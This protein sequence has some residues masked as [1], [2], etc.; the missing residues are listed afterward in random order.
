MKITAVDTTLMRIPLKQRAI[1]DS[2]SIVHDVEFMQVKIETD[3]GVTGWGMNWSYTP[4]LRAA[5][6][7]VTDNYIPLLVGQDPSMRKELTRRCYYSNHFV[8]R[9]GAAQVGLCAVE[10]ALWDIACKTANLPLWRFLGPCRDKVKAYSTDGGWLSAT[11]DELVRDAT[12]LVERGFDAV[13]IKLGRSDPHED[14]QRVGAVRKAIGPRVK[15]MTD[16]KRSAP[17]ATGAA[18]SPSM[19]CSGSKSPCTR[20]TRR[21]MLSLRAAFRSRS[22][23]VKPSTPSGIFATSSSKAE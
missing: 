1:T 12:A 17:L 7:C 20:S 19:T 21:R 9:V 16:V 3:D 15:L 8:G 23:S 6:V 14:F 11:V 10:F 18:S 13:K 2:Q 5:Q 22:P 4:G